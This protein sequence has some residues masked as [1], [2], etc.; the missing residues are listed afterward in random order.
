MGSTL[1]RLIE[2][3]HGLLCPSRV[4]KYR[5]ATR[6]LQN[7]TNEPLEG[8]LKDMKKVSALADKVSESDYSPWTK[9]DL[10]LLLKML[11]KE[12]N[13]FDQ[14]DTPKVIR[15]L[16]NKVARKDKKHPKR[17]SEEELVKML[18]RAKG[19]DKAMIHLLYEGGLRPS[20]LLS[21]KKSDIEF[22]KEGARVSVPE[23]TKTGARNILVIDSEPALAGWLAVHPIK[24]ENALLFPSE[25]GNRNFRQMTV[26]NLNKLVKRIAFE[27]GMARK[28]KS[29]D[30]RHTAASRLAGIFTDA[31]MKAYFGW[32][33]DSSMAS[34]YINIS[35]RDLDAPLLAAHGK[36]AD[37]NDLEGKLEP[38][39]CKRCGKQNAHDAAMCQ[40]CGMP[41][42]KEKAKSDMLSLQEEI[43]AL[44]ERVAAHDE[45]L[46]NNREW[47][48]GFEG[49]EL[50]EG[51][52][53]RKLKAKK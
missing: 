8:I 22:V 49:V 4:A 13:G 2:R 24:G 48:K 44:R 35:G 29:Y 39:I 31:Q 15:W 30:F 19:R 12:A 33:Q 3:K 25:Y 14:D 17:I 6:M 10:K 28:I 1:D 20:E 11:W 42:D 45:T 40:Y 38:K 52:K 32:T 43:A 37:K 34:T 16:K 9:G 21:L 47:L 50:V 51:E 41:V 5:S 23:G 7:L 27:S 26:E 53:L 18:K 46:E 36:K